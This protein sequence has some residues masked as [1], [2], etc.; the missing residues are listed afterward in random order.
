MD[1][2][3]FTSIESAFLTEEKMGQVEN[4]FC[5]NQT[6]PQVL[7]IELNLYWTC[8]ILLSTIAQCS[9]CVEF[10]FSLE[11]AWIWLTQNSHNAR[12][13]GEAAFGHICC[14][15]KLIHWSQW[16]TPSLKKENPQ[17]RQ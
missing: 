12:V 10:V 17:A 14:P 16:I 6:I 13:L 15:V 4:H 8:N 7:S 5:G 9:V 1:W 3:L 11:H 2:P